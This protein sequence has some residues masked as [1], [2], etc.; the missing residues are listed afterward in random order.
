M[1]FY[2]LPHEEPAIRG[3]HQGSARG[4]F[5]PLSEHASPPL[6]EEKLFLQRFLA[7]KVTCQGLQPPCIKHLRVYH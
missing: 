1:A 2:Y 3:C 4:G 7:F 5:S 6:K